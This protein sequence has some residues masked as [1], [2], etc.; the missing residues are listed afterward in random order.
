MALEENL[1]L[2]NPFAPLNYDDDDLSDEN[3]DADAEDSD[4]ED[5]LEDYDLSEDSDEEDENEPE[6]SDSTELFAELTRFG[7]EFDPED[8]AELDINEE[9]R[10]TILKDAI[11]YDAI[12]EKDPVMASLFQN[13]LTIEEYVNKQA[14]LGRTLDL[15]DEDLVKD[16]MWQEIAESMLKRRLI[17]KPDDKGNL[18]AADNAKVQK[19]LDS[20][21]E[22]FTPEAIKSYADEIRESVRKQAQEAIGELAQSKKK[23]EEQKWEKAAQKA[24]DFCEIIVKPENSPKWKAVL[25]QDIPI[26]IDVNAYAKTMEKYLTPVEGKNGKKETMLISKLSTE[27][28]FLRQVVGLLHHYENKSFETIEKQITQKLYK[29]LGT[30]GGKSEKPTGK[31]TKE[32]FYK[33][34]SKGF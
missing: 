5:D 3:D 15:P 7:V 24:K 6:K 10:D 27:P 12:A 30:G 9:N 34:T 25:E 11:A 16:E 33:D 19:Q 22:D 14:E 18:S 32:G 8:F 20:R 28:D 21:Y 23:L 26:S 4:A 2:E 1:D 29:K 31:K 13:G 17:S